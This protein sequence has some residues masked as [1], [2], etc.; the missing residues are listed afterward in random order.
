MT[1]ERSATR[2]GKPGHIVRVAASERFVPAEY[3][4]KDPRTKAKHKH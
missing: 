1:I 2:N 4:G 3:P